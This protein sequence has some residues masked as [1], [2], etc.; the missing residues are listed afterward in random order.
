[1]QEKLIMGLYVDDEIIIGKIDGTIQKFKEGM[2]NG[3]L[4]YFLGIEVTRNRKKREIYLSQEKFTNEIIETFNM[5]D[6][7][8]APTPLDPS[9]NLT[10]FNQNDQILTNVPYRE[11]IGKLMYLMLG[12]RP[13]IAAAV[14]Q[15]SRFLDQPRNLHWEGVK[16][17]IRYLI[18]T[19]DLQ[20]K[21]G[22]H[23]INLSCYADADYAG[24]LS[25][26]SLQ[27]DTSSSLGLD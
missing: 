2:K 22:G 20:L 19:K 24:D 13:D 9:K 17:V 23:E 21:L 5:K 25:D 12:T 14:G 10:K 1:M 6:A 26:R 7:K 4:K 15:L 18:G 3:E 8:P 27:V 16:R 11:A